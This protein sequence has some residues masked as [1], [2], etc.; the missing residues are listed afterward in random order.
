MSPRTDRAFLV[1]DRLKGSTA[2]ELRERRG[3]KIGVHAAVAVVDQLLDVLAAAHA[4]GIVH[5]DVKPANVFITTE[6]D[7]KVL[8]FGIARTRDALASGLFLTGAA[9]I[10]GTP[11]YMAPEQALPGMTEIDVRTDLWAVGATLFAL[12]SGHTV[13]EGE[14]PG[15]VLVKAATEAGRS[16][17]TVAPATPC[18][19]AEVVD[20]ALAFDKSARWTSAHDMRAALLAAYRL[21]FGRAP[22]RTSL[23]VLVDPPTS[24]VDS[25]DTLPAPRLSGIKRLAPVRKTSIAPAPSHGDMLP[26]RT[27]IPVAADVRPAILGRPLRARP[28]WVL[29]A[30]TALGV[31][32]CAA[33]WWARSPGASETPVLAPAALPPAVDAADS[34][35]PTADAT[36]A[37]PAQ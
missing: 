33:Q 25:E 20:C 31:I 8:D 21:H 11:T 27:S 15:E 2:E 10:M 7:V 22:S 6:G 9:M 32:V 35:I 16:L 28:A 26:S 18:A 19:I 17:A 30:V 4:E 3:G 34:R 5:R 23:A 36:A 13:H 14:A 29:G 1:M 12:L 24:G 37:L